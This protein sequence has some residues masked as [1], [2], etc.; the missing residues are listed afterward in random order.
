MTLVC[1]VSFERYSRLYYFDPG[2]HR[3]SVGDA[4]LI[5]TDTG[6]EVAECIWAPQEVFEPLGNL[7]QL[8]GL[9]TEADLTRREQSRGRRAEARVAAKRLIREL[10]L[11]MKVV[12]VDHLPESGLITIYFTAPERV[13]FRQL[14]RDLSRTL[15]TKVELRQ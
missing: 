1:A 9:A 15:A 13:D 10:G 5:P 3:P 7:P 8:V 4:V 11:T 2:P 12:G 14:V 6:P